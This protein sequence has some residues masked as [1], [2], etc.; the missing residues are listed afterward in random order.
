MISGQA[1]WQWRQAARRQ[2]QTSD[3]DPQEVD[4]LLRALCQVEP[5]ALRLG[6]LASQ[7]TVAS[8]LSLAELDALWQQRWRDRIP[9][10]YLVGQTTWRHL[11][12]RVTPAVLIPRPETELLI[13]LAV[14]AVAH[15]SQPERLQQGIWVDMGTGS[16]AIALGLAAAFPTAHVIGVD[17]SAAALDLAAH[18][19][20]DNDLGDRVT[21]RQGTWF[22]PLAPL[23]GQLAG[24]LSNPPYI[25]SALLE[26]LQPEVAQHEPR[27]ALDGGGDG[28]ASLQILIQQAAAFLQAGG[29][30]GVELM[31]GQAAT[32]AEQLA[33]TGHYT[34]ITRHPDLAGI[35]RF[36]LAQRR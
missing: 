29:I 22:E 11:R 7:E 20:R 26:T 19:A 3:I 2:A 17:V 36:V 35:E 32:V 1:L 9:V 12:L 21:L 25:P 15:S 23:R 14:Q 31:Q 8:T 13:D 24:M 28:L 6:T 27:L 4:W 18:N 16:G 34:A 33:A 5:L 30:W 10:Q